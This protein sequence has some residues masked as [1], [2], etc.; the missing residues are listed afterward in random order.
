MRW[1][2]LPGAAMMVATAAAAAEPFDTTAIL[3]RGMLGNEIPNTIID[4]MLA[5]AGEVVSFLMR[6]MPWM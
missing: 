2:L 4:D 5:V 3:L 1:S 6:T